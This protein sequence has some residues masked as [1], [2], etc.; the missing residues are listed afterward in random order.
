MGP[1]TSELSANYNLMLPNEPGTGGQLLAVGANLLGT[2]PN[3]FRQLEWVDG[4]SAVGV[5][6]LTAGTGVTLSPSSGLGV[7]EISASGTSGCSDVFKTIK[8]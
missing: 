4:G 3:Q 7:V 8:V 5:T 6:Q 2:A 1:I